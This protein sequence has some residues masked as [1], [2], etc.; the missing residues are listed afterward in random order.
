MHSFA[1]YLP[2]HWK[3]WIAK[4]R[5]GQLQA[6]D[7]TRTVLI[8]FEDGSQAWF[9]NAFCVEDKKHKELCIFTEHCGYFVISS[10]GNSYQQINMLDGYRET[11][12]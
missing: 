6:S 9:N 3:A 5:S 7:F 8:N 12:G 2:P 11:P 4:H 10:R 1:K